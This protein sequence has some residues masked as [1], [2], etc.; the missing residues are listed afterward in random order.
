MYG[1]AFYTYKICA[2]IFFGHVRKCTKIFR[3][4]AHVHTGG[5]HKKKPGPKCS[6]VFGMKSLTLW[7]LSTKTMYITHARGGI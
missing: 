2:Q 5:E 4:C 1:G 3:S 7:D 6:C